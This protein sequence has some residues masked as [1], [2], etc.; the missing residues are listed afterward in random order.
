MKERERLT[1]IFGLWHFVHGVSMALL[2]WSIIWNMWFFP[3]GIIGSFISFY[4]ISKL[5]EVLK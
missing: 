5:K 4:K 1:R 3:I 2:I